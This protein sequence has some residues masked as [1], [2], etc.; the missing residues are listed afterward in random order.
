MPLS[1]LPFEKGSCHSAR[2][3]SSMSPA[4]TH[5]PALLSLAALALPVALPVA[6]PAPHT[7]FLPRAGETGGAAS[8]RLSQRRTSHPGPVLA[9]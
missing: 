1:R 6:L 9:R 8:P 5:Q 7:Q 3:G 4:P 2:A